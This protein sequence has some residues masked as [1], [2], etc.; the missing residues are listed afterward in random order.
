MVLAAQLLPPEILD[1]PKW[2]VRLQ[3]DNQA[4]Q[5][6]VMQL[7]SENRLLLDRVNQHC[8]ENAVFQIQPT[9]PCP[10]RGSATPLPEPFSGSC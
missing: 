9:V 2:T 5:A 4:L 3:A 8:V 6:Q 1:L 7:T 10:E